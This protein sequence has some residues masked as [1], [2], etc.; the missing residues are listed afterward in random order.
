MI[1]DGAPPRRPRSSL[2]NSYS[3][4]ARPTSWRNWPA[5][6]SPP[7]PPERVAVG[8]CRNVRQSP[9]RRW[10]FCRKARRPS[11]CSVR[12]GI[13]RFL[14]AIL[15]REAR[16]RVVRSGP[17]SMTA[18]AWDAR[19]LAGEAVARVMSLGV[20][21]E[22]QPVARRDALPGRRQFRNGNNC[23]FDPQEWATTCAPSKTEPSCC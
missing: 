17:T 14:R 16:S 9:S 8:L 4:V 21:R 12:G 11:S 18:R 5:S 2:R 15:G 22:D 23:F 6:D 19:R 7:R 3:C 1:R 10:P 20:C 13:S